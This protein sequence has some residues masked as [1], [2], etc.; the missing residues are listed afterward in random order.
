MQIHRSKIEG[1]KAV[2]ERLQQQQNEIYD[3]LIDEIKPT[4]EQESF[5]WDYVFNST[6]MD[7]EE[8]NQMVER[9]IYG[10]NC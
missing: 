5:I 3:R 4:E 6:P 1:T 2:I 8:Y 10:N 9:G 7:N